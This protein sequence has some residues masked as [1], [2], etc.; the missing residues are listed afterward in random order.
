MFEPISGTFIIGIGHKARHGKDTTAT[1]II[2]ATGGLA[3]RFS[4]ADDLYATAR[5]IF[6]M[7]KKDGPT[8]QWLG[9]EGFRKKDEDFWLK[10]L[11]WNL[12]N[13]RP[14]IAVIADVRFPNEAE[15]VKKMGGVTIKVSRFNKDGSLYVVSDRDPNHPS[16]T[17]LDTYTGWDY[18][19]ENSSGDLA[20]LHKQADDILWDLRD[21]IGADF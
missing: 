10:C 8:L 15:F 7:T 4:F 12:Y 2:R 21:R 9:T 17:S 1:H 20:P 16:E 14:R 19:I 13:K 3:E 18:S 5:V 6:G 11:Y